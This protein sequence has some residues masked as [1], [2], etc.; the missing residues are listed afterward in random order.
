MNMIKKPIYLICLL[1][2]WL[3]S[4][5]NDYLDDHYGA[6][7]RSEGR[8]LME[9]MEAD[10][11]LTSFCQVV[12]D[13]GLDSL[14]STD[15]TFTVWAPD[16]NAMSGYQ[17]NGLTIDQFLKNHINRFIYEPSD[18]VDKPS[19]RVKML[20]GKFQEYASSGSTYTFS[21]VTMASTDR[22]A[23]NGL[24][25]ILSER[26]PFYH[27]M[28]E[29][30]KLADNNTDSISKY[31][32][33]FDVYTFNESAST[34]IGKNQMGKLVYD[35][36]FNY[37][38]DWMRKYGHI[39]QEDSLYTMIVPTDK[40][41]Q[42][43]YKSIS[44]Y[45]RTFGACASSS[46]NAINVPTRTYQLDDVLADS[47]TR[48][49]TK[50]NMCQD[51]VFRKK[52]DF[53]NAPGD[54]LVAT[55]GNVFHHPASLIDGAV[56][57]MVS[58]GIIWKTDKL[59]YNPLD[60]FLKKICVEAENT[61]N[62]TDVYA[63]VT[64]RSAANTTYSDSVSNVR[65]IEVTQTTTSARTQPMVQFTIPNTLA[66]KYNVYVVFA[67]ASAYMTGVKADSTRVNFYLNYVHED[68]T[69]KEDPVISGTITHG[70][71][72]TKMFVKQIDFPFSNYSASPFSGT[73]NQDK[74]CVKLRVQANVASSET[75][76]LTRT[77]RIDCIILEPVNE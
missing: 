66:A 40:G 30:I 70:N 74:D 18:L 6:N 27:N 71:R 53:F 58:N 25:H 29:S 5:Q 22:L 38:N 50:Q 63:S 65:Y 64:A 21:G 12:K 54:S 41:W 19:I 14:L 55:S 26:I 15:Q 56:K 39:Y 10:P 32:K 8:N 44:G 45:F 77:M 23:S 60:C 49:Y 28:Y 76:T 31:L 13:Q 3:C 16:N 47:L 33:R 52:V 24:V 69:M 20:N 11:E 59:L 75:A 51:L 73:A 34:A 68:G 2:G 36:V 46:V 43:G 62:R 7:G 61:A 42:N 57:E 1:L 9:V 72:M 35:S 67:P 17:E 37:R 4:C 48:A